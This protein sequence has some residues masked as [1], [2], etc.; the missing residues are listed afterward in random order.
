MIKVPIRGI[1]VKNFHNYKHDKRTLL[2]NCVEPELG[3]HIF[4]RAFDIIEKEKK[5]KQ[6]SF[7][8]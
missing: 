1:I 6:I 2:N 7:F 8:N 5:H 3:L 4:N